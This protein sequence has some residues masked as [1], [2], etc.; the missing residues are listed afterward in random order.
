MFRCIL[1]PTTC[2]RAFK[3]GPDLCAMTRTCRALLHS[4]RSEDLHKTDIPSQQYRSSI[5]Q[6]VYDSTYHSG[7]THRRPLTL[8]MPGSLCLEQYSGRVRPK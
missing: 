7:C 4:V 1:C 3:E 2:N 8:N 6:V 5:R